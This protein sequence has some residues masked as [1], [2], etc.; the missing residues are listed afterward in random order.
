MPYNG[1]ITWLFAI[2]H[3]NQV[4]PTKGKATM[5]KQWMATRAVY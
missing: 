1:M 2:F 5:R 4:Y 3:L